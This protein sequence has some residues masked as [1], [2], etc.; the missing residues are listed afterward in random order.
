L[1]YKPK[2]L[3]CLQAT[4]TGW[5][6]PA[7]AEP[8]IKM[9]DFPYSRATMFMEAAVTALHHTSKENVKWVLLS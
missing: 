8:I 5:Q 1:A 6:G 9:L 7:F 4:L 3:A 2:A